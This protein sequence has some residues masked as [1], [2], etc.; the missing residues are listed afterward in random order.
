MADTVTI[1]VSWIIVGLIG[2]ALGL[3]TAYRT[4]PRRPG[5]WIGVCITGFVGG[6]IG[7]F[8]LAGVGLQPVSW[9]GSL[10]LAYLAAVVVFVALRR[11]LVEST[12]LDREH[13]PESAP[14]QR[15]Q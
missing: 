15:R 2:A 3:F 1:L 14:Q 10:A 12:E 9:L 6:W 11:V 4:L 8:V 13:E 7:G 5:E